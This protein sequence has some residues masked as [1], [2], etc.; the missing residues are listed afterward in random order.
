MECGQE[1]EYI[2]PYREESTDEDFDLLQVR[3]YKCTHTLTRTLTQTHSQS[4]THATCHSCRVFEYFF[5]G[6][7]S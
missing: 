4:H 2:E 3:K 5:N 6:L 1:E 7:V